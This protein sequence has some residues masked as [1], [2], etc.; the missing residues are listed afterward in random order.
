MPI[1]QREDGILVFSLPRFLMLG[2]MPPYYNNYDDDTDGDD[3]DTTECCN[4]TSNNSS[5][6]AFRRHCAFKH[7]GEIEFTLNDIQCH[8]ILSTFL[9]YTSIQALDYLAVCQHE[10]Q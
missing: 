10:T 4:S 8:H 9:T 5:T 6:A 2:S 3:G 1:D 7:Y